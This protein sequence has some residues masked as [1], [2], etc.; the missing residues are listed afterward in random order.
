MAYIGLAMPAIKPGTGKG[1][2]LGRAVKV[3]IEPQYAEA[4]LY[5]DNI[6]AESDRSFK[7]A[8][9]TLETTSL[10]IEA[11]NA[12]LGHE[13][14][15][16]KMET[17]YKASDTANYVG[18]G[19]YTEEVVDGEHKFVSIWLEKVKFSD[20]KDNYETK[21]DSGT[22][23]TPSIEGDVLTGEN[24]IWKTLKINDTEAAAQE[25]LSE[26]AG[27]T[28]TPPV[29]DTPAEVQTMMKTKK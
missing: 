10:P 4:A 15:E 1:F 22:Y 29:P 21:G 25:W 17:T 28:E 2:R 8:K 20:T 23:K 9:I 26:K 19:F 13:V 16:D 11:H 6:K 18:F 7:S 14:S 12:L 24:G 27:I 3:D 5:G